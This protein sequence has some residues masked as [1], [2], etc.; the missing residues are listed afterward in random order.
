[1]NYRLQ[2]LDDVKNDLSDAVL[3]YEERSSGL[4]LLLFEEWERI[5][6]YIKQYPEHY[7]LQYKNTRHAYFN[8]FPYIVVYEFDKPLI[9]VYALLHAKQHPR[10]RTKRLQK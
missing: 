7:Q 9:V 3:W 6:S 4:G 2:I 5:I 10:K 1:M 8:K